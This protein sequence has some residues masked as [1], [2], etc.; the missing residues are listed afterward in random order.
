LVFKPP[1]A[2]LWRHQKQ[3]S[4][5]AMLYRNPDHPPRQP[6]L[7]RFAGLF[8]RIGERRRRL[9]ELDLLAMSE[10]L[11]RDL[12]LVDADLSDLIRHK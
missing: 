11:R 8:R 10:H 3:P 9:A 5:I 2:H 12:G 6:L 1:R 7:G 4:E